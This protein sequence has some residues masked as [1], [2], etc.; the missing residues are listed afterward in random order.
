MRTPLIIACVLMTT[1]LSAQHVEIQGKAKIT[2][3][4]TANTVNSLVVRKPDG[5]LAT[6]QVS[7]LAL[8]PSMPDTT[9]TFANDL[10]LAMAVCQCD[11][12]PPALVASALDHG[13]TAEELIGFGVN[14]QDL[15]D[16]GVTPLELYQ[17][18]VPYNELMGKLYQGGFIFHMNTTT[19]VGLACLTSDIAPR[20][21][22]CYGT[23]LPG[24]QGIAIGTGL[25][26]SLDID[27]G[28][29]TPM[30]AAEDCLTLVHNSQ[31]DWYLPSKDELWT[32]HITIGRGAPASHFNLA[33][34][35]DGWYYWASTEWDNNNAHALCMYLDIYGCPDYAMWSAYKSDY[36]WIRPI[37][38][39]TP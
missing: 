26:N 39:F 33:N 14:A 38:T 36:L 17:L 35:G 4:D 37:R 34:M 3:M 10:A 16:V 27:A 2:V 31:S 18:G 13:Y 20:Q 5:E 30:I 11:D 7:S 15:L 32:L 28:C 21:W 1:G 25:Q 22:G 23:N 8:P 6:R 24:A 9:R 12:L 29:S 19:G